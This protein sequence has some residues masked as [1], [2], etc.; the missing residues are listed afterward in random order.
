MTISSYAQ[1]L[2]C[3]GGRAARCFRWFSALWCFKHFFSILL[4][5]L[6]MFIVLWSNLHNIQCALSLSLVRIEPVNMDSL[7][8]A[9]LHNLQCGVVLLFHQPGSY[10]SRI[11]FSFCRIIQQ[12]PLELREEG[13]P[14]LHLFS[15]I[16]T[17]PG[18]DASRLQQKLIELREL[19]DANLVESAVRQE[20]SYPQMKRGQWM[21]A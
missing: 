7:L 18:D 11:Q 16:I 4:V 6:G 9:T 3:A 12:S 2:V 14:T 10:P 19:V 21:N 20:C 8:S 5:L 1:L 13:Y 17:D 15:F